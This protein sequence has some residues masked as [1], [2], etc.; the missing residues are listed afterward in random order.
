MKHDE[1]IGQVQHRAKL[2]SRGEAEVATRAVLETLAERLLGNEPADAAAQLPKGIAGYLDHAWSG[3]GEP[4]S[5]D[6]FFR[7]VSQRAEIDLPD[8]VFQS[9]VVIEVLQEAVSQGKV[10]DMRSQLPQ[11]YL[12]LFEAGSEGK[13]KVNR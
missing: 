12:T 7:R 6:E 5:I 3:V 9:R 13:M 11:D 8:A 1:F 2:P 10:E 4:F